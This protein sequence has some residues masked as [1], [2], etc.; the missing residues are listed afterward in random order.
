MIEAVLAGLLGLLIG[1]FLNVCIYRLPRDLSVTQPRRSF[2]PECER[3][4]AWYDNIPLVS[5]AVLGGKCRHCGTRISWRYPV[6]EALT[7]GLFFTVVAMHG[8]SALSMKLCVFSA[9]LVA[10][11]FSDLE[12]RILPDEFTLGGTL[13]GLVFAWLVPFPEAFSYFFFPIDWGMPVLSVIEAAFTAALGSFGL[14]AMAWLYLRL[15]G[16]EGMGLGDVKMIAMLGAF[17]GLHL[18]LLT[19]VFASLLGVFVGLS[20]I[21][22]TGKDTASYELP[23]GSFMGIS[24]I[25]TGVFGAHIGRWYWSLWQ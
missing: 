20:Y 7:G 11:I 1:S 5:Y 12:E 13:L 10:L 17:L 23:F 16:R 8:L 21:K 14:W 2:C 3:T 4:I 25:A 22:L 6:V 9:L 24:G 19:M 15:R 18:T